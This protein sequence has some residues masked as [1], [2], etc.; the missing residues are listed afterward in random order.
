MVGDGEK[1]RKVLIRRVFSSV[2]ATLPSKYSRCLAIYIR[3]V[4]DLCIM[5][6]HSQHKSQPLKETFRTRSNHRSTGRL[7]IPKLVD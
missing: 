2:L 5:T 1:R 3:H 4:L 7:L 6:L